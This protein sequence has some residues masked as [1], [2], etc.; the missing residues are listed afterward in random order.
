MADIFAGTQPPAWLVN[1]TAQQPGALGDVAGL[2]VGGLL[3]SLQRDPNASPNAGFLES[4]KGVKEGLAEARLNEQNPLWRLQATQIKAATI[5]RMAQAETAYAKAQSQ[6]AD[7]TAWMQ[8][9]PTLAPWLSA[10]PEQRKDLP[11]P[12]VSSKIGVSAVQKAAIADQN[13]F[14]KQQAQQQSI[15]ATK[16]RVDNNSTKLKDIQ[17]W[18]NAYAELTPQQR[19]QVDALPNSGRD[20]G[21][22]LTPAAR[23]MINAL[24]VADGKPPVG[25]APTVAAAQVRAQSAKEIEAQ[26]AS[27]KSALEEQRQANRKE[28]QAR[29]AKYKID[30]EKYKTELN[31]GK[32]GKVIG[33]DE[34]INRHYNSVFNAISKYKPAKDAALE[35]ISILDNTYGAMAPAPAAPV[36]PPATGGESRMVDGY[37]QTDEGPKNKEATTDA[38]TQAAPAA[39][40]ASPAP[41]SSDT[42]K[43]LKYDPT[44]DELK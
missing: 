21:G 34:F 16:L 6:I 41:A 44:T 42:K 43:I 28:L 23:S 33:K 22:V 25:T 31:V 24:H 29:A 13:Y 19:I 38:G 32:N 17:L 35:T 36:T 12:N 27:E 37:I 39:P 1:E 30:L 26:K 4:R 8:E 40:A 18:D 11:I 9:A 14:I 2:A 15:E 10:T 5:G 20:K 7:T 3:N